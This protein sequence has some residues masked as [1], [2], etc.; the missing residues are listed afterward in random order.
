GRRAR[1]AA[2]PAEDDGA[3]AT[4]APD[5]GAADEA[6]AAWTGRRPGRSPTLRDD[7]LVSAKAQLSEAVEELLDVLRTPDVV[8]EIGQVDR[9]NLAKYLTIAK[10]R[11]ENAIALVRSEGP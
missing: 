10:L 1:V 2:A 8:R 6:E 7:S 3:T 4:E 5:D 9:A 11:L